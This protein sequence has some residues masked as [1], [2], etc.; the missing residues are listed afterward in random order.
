MLYR[1]HMR[2]KEFAL[3]SVVLSKQISFH[4]LAPLGQA[5]PSSTP[6]KASRVEDH[7]RRRISR[8]LQTPVASFQPTHPHPEGRA[9]PVR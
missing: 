8:S 9:A 2:R 3:G 6:S 4:H 1:V 7:F 5:E